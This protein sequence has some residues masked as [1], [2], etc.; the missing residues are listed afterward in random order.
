MAWRL[1][2]YAPVRGILIVALLASGCIMPFAIPPTKVEVG[3][4]SRAGGTAPSTEMIHVAVGSH[5]A[6]GTR[7]RT[8][9]FDLGMGWIFS[10]DFATEMASNTN[11]LYVD[12]AVFVDRTHASRTG[13]GVR[14]D[15]SDAP[16]GV[17][18]RGVLR[19]DY[20]WF[21][22]VDKPFKSDSKCGTAAG[23][24]VGSAGVGVF[25]EAGVMRLPSGEAAWTATAGVS[26]RLPS[27]LGVAIGIPWCK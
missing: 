17:Q 10:H 12:G 8:Q 19:I 18:L 6:S 11:G 3:A 7:S 20:E 2:M 21:T 25:T 27:A 9:K 22:P 24:H 5:L 15:V 23:V 1:L 14:A 13:V 26:F 16:G 4:A